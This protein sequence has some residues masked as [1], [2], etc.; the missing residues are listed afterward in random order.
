M[1]ERCQIYKTAVSRKRN[2]QILQETWDEANESYC[3][4]PSKVCVWSCW[5]RHLW[6]V[7]HIYGV[8]TNPSRIVQQTDIRLLLCPWEQLQCTCCWLPKGLSASIVHILEMHLAG[9]NHLVS[10]PS[11]GR[12]AFMA[13]YFF[14]SFLIH[15]RVVE[16]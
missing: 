2:D 4:L 16:I 9:H 11:H 5:K 15:I 6:Y 14:A 10:W 8:F 3:Y 12:T 13:M 1:R 7:H